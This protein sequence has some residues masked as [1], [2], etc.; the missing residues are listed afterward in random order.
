MRFL[1]L[2][3]A[4]QGDPLWGR[5][6]IMMMKMMMKYADAGLML[7]HFWR[8]CPTGMA[9]IGDNIIAPQHNLAL[10]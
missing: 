1:T 6:P 9:R 7:F 4:K 10:E 3:D 2:N 8:S 5:D